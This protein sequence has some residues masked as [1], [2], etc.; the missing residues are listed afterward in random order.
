[1]G[2]LGL[3]HKL[4]DPNDPNLLVY[5]SGSHRSN[6]GQQG[7]VSPGGFWGESSS[8]SF[9]LPDASCLRWGVA[10]SPAEGL[11]GPLAG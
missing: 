7:S 11:Q 6:T 4:S 8:L 10:P 5:A 9:G 3:C 1:M 2:I